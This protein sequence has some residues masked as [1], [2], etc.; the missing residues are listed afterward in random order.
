MTQ[1]LRVYETENY[2][3]EYRIKLQDRLLGNGV[4]LPDYL[5]IFA[6]YR[7]RSLTF[8]VYAPIT[9]VICP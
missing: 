6:R 3:T 5:F 4:T 9:L 7:T 1:R 8:K 2:P